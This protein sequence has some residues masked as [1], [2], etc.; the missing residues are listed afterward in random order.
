MPLQRESARP[1]GDAMA[2][3]CAPEH[4]GCDGPWSRSERALVHARA[5]TWRWMGSRLTAVLLLLSLAGNG[6][7]DEQTKSPREEYQAALVLG[8]EQ[9]FAIRTRGTL[10]LDY[11]K[12][13]TAFSAGGTMKPHATLPRVKE[14]GYETRAT[15]HSRVIARTDTDTVFAMRLTDY[16]GKLGGQDDTRKT[17]FE[18]PFVVRMDASGSFHSFEFSPGYPGD[19]SQA[20]ASMVEPLQVVF[21]SSASSGDWESTE[22]SSQGE[23]TVRYRVVAS[24]GDE[25]TLDRKLLS[26]QRELPQLPGLSSG[27]MHHNQRVNGSEGRVVWSRSKGLVSLQRS[28]DVAAMDNDAELSRLR[29][30]FTAEKTSASKVD[31]PRTLDDARTLIAGGTYAR[32]AFYKVPDILRASLVKLTSDD[33]AKRFHEEFASSPAEAVNNLRFFV[34]TKPEAALEL[35]QLFDRLAPSKDS[36]HRVGH[37]YGALGLAGHREAQLAMAD[38]IRTGSYTAISREMAVRGTLSVARPEPELVDAV[39]G[40]RQALATQ[41]GVGNLHLSLVTNTY[42]A[43]GGIEHAVPKLSQVVVRNLANRLAGAAD[44]NERMQML[45][46]LGNVGDLELVM[47]VTEQYLRHPDPDLRRHAFHTF[48]KS[49]ADAD[50][51]RFASYVQAEKD[52]M[53]RKAA[54]VVAQAMPGTKAVHSWARQQIMQ[55]SDRD[56]RARLVGVL[57]DGLA[58]SPE[59]EAPLRALLDVESDREVRK[60]IYRYLSPAAAG[61]AP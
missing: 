28:E 22:R 56:S 17:L 46:A 14:H 51:A 30:S 16:A 23:S 49:G 60:T 48:Q 32:A 39:W 47:P 21:A 34:R 9:A 45:T 31:L 57:G 33:A 53:V 12:W 40:Y 52:P 26:V 50:V 5:S 13:A 58:V 29:S 59:N 35:A 3:M 42:G 20:I 7:C 61:G 24:A 54:I 25:V 19:V 4:D 8:S 1:K 55:E 15:L 37:F 10:D 2:G 36:M 27:R 18:A 44:K 41:A 11:A 38:V 43:L 6:G